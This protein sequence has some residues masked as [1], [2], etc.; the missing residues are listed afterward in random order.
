M[1]WHVFLICLPHAFATVEKYFEED[2]ETFWQNRLTNEINS[3]NHDTTDI[4]DYVEFRLSHALKP[5]SYKVQIIPDVNRATFRGTCVVLFNVVAPTRVIRLHKD[6]HLRV[7]EE[8]IRVFSRDE[9]KRIRRIYDFE[10]GVSFL[11]IDMYEFLSQGENYTLYID[12]FHGE[13]AMRDEG[14]IVGY[15]DDEDKQG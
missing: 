1:W 12:K 10:P 6:P 14:L 7:Y 11:N 4:F 3:T 2:D 8:D 9:Q 5:I 13:M 15:Y